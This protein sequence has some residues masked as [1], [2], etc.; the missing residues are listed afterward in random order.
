MDEIVTLGFLAVIFLIFTV[1][2]FQSN[3]K[4]L[5]SQVPSKKGKKFSP[6]GVCLSLGWMFLFLTLATVGLAV[7]FYYGSY[8]GRLQGRIF[9]L[10]QGVCWVLMVI[11]VI[12]TIIFIMTECRYTIKKDT[13]GWP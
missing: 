13:E 3:G 10:A 6:R 11:Y 8:L 9:A 5:V 2:F 1:I 7:I 12:A 4:K